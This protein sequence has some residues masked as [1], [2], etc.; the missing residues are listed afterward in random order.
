M[1]KMSKHE[2]LL[3]MYAFSEGTSQGK[4]KLLIFTNWG[5][6][7]C[8]L[9]FLVSQEHI[10]QNKESTIL[11]IVLSGD[12]DPEVQKELDE[13]NHEKEEFILLKDANVL[14]SGGFRAHF[15]E[16]ALFLN[17]IEGLSVGC[18]EAQQPN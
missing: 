4:N 18:L 15:N 12:Q 5:L 10:E 8:K 16:L 7:E 3:R 6:V 1:D 13:Q 14:Y 11:Q 2:M 9:N 17:S